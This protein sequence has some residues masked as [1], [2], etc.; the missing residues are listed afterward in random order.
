[1]LCIYLR[2]NT[3]DNHSV[4]MFAPR[5]ACR[6]VKRKKKRKEKKI[7]K[8][9]QEHANDILTRHMSGKCI[10]LHEFR[11]AAPTNSPRNRTDTHGKNTRV[12]Y[13]FL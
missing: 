2:D 13:S 5:R 7:V 4:R 11:D 10:R 3:F 12:L 1:M 8:L 9:G 6:D